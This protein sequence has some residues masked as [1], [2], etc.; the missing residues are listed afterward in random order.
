VHIFHQK[1]QDRNS[2]WIKKFVSWICGRLS[3]SIDFDLKVELAYT[4]A[5]DGRVSIESNQI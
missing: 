4:R 2:L 5:L 3:Y 1:K